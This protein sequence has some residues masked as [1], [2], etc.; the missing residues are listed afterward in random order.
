MGG[1]RH[2]H[3]HSHSHSGQDHAAIHVA[4][5]DNVLGATI[6]VS[7]IIAALYFSLSIAIDIKRL[8]TRIRQSPNA[9]PDR[10]LTTIL[11]ILATASFTT[12][13]YHML[14]VLI[15]SYTQW[16]TTHGSVDTRT[17]VQGMLPSPSNLLSYLSKLLASLGR[18]TRTSTLFADFAHALL[19]APNRRALVELTLLYSVGWSSWMSAQGHV[20]AI[21]SLWKYFIL[22]Q[23]LPTSF[24][25]HLFLLTLTLQRSQSSPPQY[26]AEAEVQSKHRPAFLSIFFAAAT[27]LAKASDSLFWIAE[28][29]ALILLPYFV[30]RRIH[31]LLPR[32]YTYLAYAGIAA[33]A[34][35]KIPAVEWRALRLALDAHPAV[36][37][38]GYDL[39]LGVVG[40]VTYAAY[41]SVV[42]PHRGSG[43]AALGQDRA[44]LR[45]SGELQRKVDGGLKSVQGARVAPASG[46]QGRLDANLKALAE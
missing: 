28:I 26:E 13:S 18:W 29:R 44:A 42:D 31:L 19:S 27:S 14:N 38:L 40:A 25:Q 17:L 3:S 12:L 6:F 16:T 35:F 5:P 9:K 15:Q 46:L 32:A 11:T 34:A 39:V 4:D 41:V 30:P 24:A 22:A 10:F 2:S 36:S 8:K 20:H 21:P 45:G 7:Y 1:H 23:I 43:P 37:A 33:Y